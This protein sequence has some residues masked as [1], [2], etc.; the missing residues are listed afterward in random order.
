MKND[1]ATVLEAVKERL[2]EIKGLVSRMEEEAPENLMRLIQKAGAVFITGKGRSGYI[3]SCLA[4]RLM[5]M[6][7]TVHV[8]GEATCRRIGPEDLMIAVSCS[9]STVTTVELAK[10]SK[11]S[12]ADVVA[13]TANPDS[14]LAATSDHIVNVP[15][16]GEDVK[17]SHRCVLGPY[18]NTLFEQTLLLYFDAVVHYMLKHEGIPPGRLQQMHTNLE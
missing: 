13:V 14:A 7:F 2:D 17:E 1:N 5:Q 6:G 4:M 9:G 3:A 15:V 12:N 10:I 8:P 18:N 11:N 16:H